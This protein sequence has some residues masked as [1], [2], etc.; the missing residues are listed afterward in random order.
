MKSQSHLVG[1]W[2]AEPLLLH[3]HVAHLGHEFIR[4]DEEAR[5]EQEGEDVRP[6]WRERE[7]R[8]GGQYKNKLI[9]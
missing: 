4:V 3:A 7:R 6:L 1:L 8:Q 2:I 9:I 5:A